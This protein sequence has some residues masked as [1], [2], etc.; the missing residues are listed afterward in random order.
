MS[1]HRIPAVRVGFRKE[2]ELILHSFVA[3]GN[4]IGDYPTLARQRTGYSSIKETI[5]FFRG[6]GIQIY[7]TA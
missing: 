3:D 6:R 4:Q 7:G 5:D 1:R 2:K